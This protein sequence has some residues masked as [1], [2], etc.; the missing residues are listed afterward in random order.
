MSASTVGACI[1]LGAIA[2]VMVAGLAAVAAMETV[3]KAHPSLRLPPTPAAL[4][5]R[6]SQAFVIHDMKRDD[7]QDNAQELLNVAWQVAR[8][9]IV[10]PATI[11]TRDAKALRAFNACP[12][13]HPNVI[14]GAYG[15]TASHLAVMETALRE[16]PTLAQPV[17]NDWLLIFEDDATPQDGVTQDQ[18]A[19]LI[20]DAISLASTL[21]VDAVFFTWLYF[22]K[23]HCRPL[24]RVGPQMWR[25][26]AP[27]S[28]VAYA[29]RGSLLPTLVQLLRANHCVWPVDEVYRLHMRDVLL[30]TPSPST[31]PAASRWEN[32]KLPFR[33][34]LFKQIDTPSGIQV[35]R[36]G[37]KK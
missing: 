16:Q 35:A 1:A 6:V 33:D 4:P 13:P 12:Q 11:P 26:P 10:W 20:Q 9:A 36:G 15:A 18:A 31:R 32:G 19:V 34:T 27:V 25:A 21:D 29:V 22:S 23:R 28:A 14:I 2:L 17:S 8:H 24:V 7:R 30:V 37:K 5:A 3:N